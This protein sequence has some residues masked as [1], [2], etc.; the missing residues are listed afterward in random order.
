MIIHIID[1]Q[2]I[3]AMGMKKYLEQ[4]LD[5]SATIFTYKAINSIRTKELERSELIIINLDL[6]EDIFYQ[7]IDQL[8]KGKAGFKLL[9]LVG[10]EKRDLLFKVNLKIF[11]A[12]VINSVILDELRILFSFF[13]ENKKYYSP[14]II[15]YINNHHLQRFKHIDYERN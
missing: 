11:D 3:Y 5:D 9:G 14:E 12:L 10:S 1:Q 4:L 8:R 7:Q 6:Y 2:P 13:H 15:E